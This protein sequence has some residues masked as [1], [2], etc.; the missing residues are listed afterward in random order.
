[1]ILEPEVRSRS[2][3]R[4]FARQRE[5]RP[6]AAFQSSRIVCRSSAGS[7]LDLSVR[8]TFKIDCVLT[9]PTV[10]VS[11]MRLVYILVSAILLTCI[12]IQAYAIEPGAIA[13]PSMSVPNMDMPQPR[14]TPNMDMPDPK[15]KQPVKPDG[16]ADQILNQTGNMSNNQTQVSQ[17]LQ[18]VMPMD[19]SGR[20]SIRFDEGSSR[21]LN[22]NLWS[23]SG[24]RILGYGTLN[25]GSAPQSVTVSGSVIGQELILSTKPATPEYANQETD[26]YDLDLFMVNNTLSGTYVM[27]S[28]EQSVV[29]GNATATKL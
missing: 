5:R 25:E 27:R 17:T 2:I 7:D 8:A 28:G 12:S 24:N 19:V 13:V 6:P 20:W 21:S 3:E 18:E 22:V 10:E 26:E 9:N 4:P 14:I 15:P 11:R 16:S 1:M 23:S 29:N